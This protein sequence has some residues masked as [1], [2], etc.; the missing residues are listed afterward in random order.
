MIILTFQNPTELITLSLG[1]MSP[2]G[3]VRKEC[4]SMYVLFPLICTM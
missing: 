2:E 4:D 3:S 1:E